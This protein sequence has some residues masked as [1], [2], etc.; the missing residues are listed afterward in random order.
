VI[1][2]GWGW[3]KWRFGLKKPS[4]DF[5]FWPFPVVPSEFEDH[6]K[7]HLSVPLKFKV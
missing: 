7:M 2:A 5:F 6:G 1:E 4:Y 3:P